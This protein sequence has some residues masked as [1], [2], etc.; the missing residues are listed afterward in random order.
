MKPRLA[1]LALVLLGAV[2][3]HLLVI[4][5]LPQLIMQRTMSA[6]GGFTGSNVFI[7]TPPPGAGSRA[8]VRP[9]PDLLYSIC[10]LDLSEGPVR[11]RAAVSEPYSSLSV[12]AANSDNIFVVNDR[13]V[14][15]DHFEAVLATGDAPIDGAGAPVVRLPSAHGIALVRRVITDPAQLAQLEAQRHDSSCKLIP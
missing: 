15:G 7:H 2:L 13:Q 5:C 3:V 11:I 4:H 12:F 14:S 9:S 10:I 6:I 8:V 1:W